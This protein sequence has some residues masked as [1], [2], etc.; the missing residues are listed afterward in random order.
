M[1]GG[2]GTLSVIS[3]LDYILNQS[4]YRKVFGRV[5]GTAKA[6]SHRESS[7][8]SKLRAQRKLREEMTGPST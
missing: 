4:R 8:V 3:V 6:P 5:T 1:H 2:T 7:S